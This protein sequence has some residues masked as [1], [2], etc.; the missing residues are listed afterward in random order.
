MNTTRAAHNE[1]SLQNVLAK[2]LAGW[3]LELTGRANQLKR[4]M[5]AGQKTVS[6]TGDLVMYISHQAGKMGKNKC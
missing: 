6:G 3:E 5:Q 1:L 4:V 2:T